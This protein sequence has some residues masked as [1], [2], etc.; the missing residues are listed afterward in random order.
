MVSTVLLYMMSLRN[1]F[2]QEFD[3]LA[4][5]KICIN[6]ATTLPIII[7]ASAVCRSV[8]PVHIHGFYNT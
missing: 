7:W 4:R 1:H 2:W 8:F 5:R 6:A 3:P